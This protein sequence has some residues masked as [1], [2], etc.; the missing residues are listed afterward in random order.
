MSNSF[1]RNDQLGKLMPKNPGNGQIE[2]VLLSNLLFL[3]AVYHEK[4]GW[5]FRLA[6]F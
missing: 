2:L 3:V 4:K 6:E 5:L 1:I